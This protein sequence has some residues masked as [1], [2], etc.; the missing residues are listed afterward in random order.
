M[1][2]GTQHIPKLKWSGGGQLFVQATKVGDYVEL[3]LPA[4]ENGPQKVTVYA[5]KSYDY[6]ILRF[7]VNGKVALDNWDGYNPTSIRS[8]P[9]PLGVFEPRDGKITLRVEVAGSNPQ[10]KSPK[11]YFG[12]DCVTL[13]EP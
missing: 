12:I 9:I 1:K 11:M 8:D 2:I 10:S 5:T 13:G 3:T 4:K 6:G 7:E